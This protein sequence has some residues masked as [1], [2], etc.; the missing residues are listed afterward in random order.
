M[1]LYAGGPGHGAASLL[2]RRLAH[3]I[4]SLHLIPLMM[5]GAMATTVRYVQLPRLSEMGVSPDVV[6]LTLGTAELTRMTLLPESIPSVCRDLYDHGKA[7]LAALQSLKVTSTRIILTTLYDFGDGRDANLT[8]AV[9]HFNT[10]ITRLADEQQVRVADIH[11][12]FRGHGLATGDPFQ[13]EAAPTNTELF[14]RS[15]ADAI[16]VP[17]AY[18]AATIATAFHETLSA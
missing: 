6:T 8:E 7:I 9:A 1:D 16:P 15:G 5:E 4:P 17:N 12:A 18:G 11:S 2:H 3:D 10:T 14:L 13:P